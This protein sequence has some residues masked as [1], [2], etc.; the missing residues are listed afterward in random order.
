MGEADADRIP[1][2]E[3]RYLT[4]ELKALHPEQEGALYPVPPHLLPSELQDP[5]NLSA[6]RELAP[7]E[8]AD[9][10]I[11]SWLELAR[12]MGRKKKLWKLFKKYMYF[13]G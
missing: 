10:T 11:Q 12:R 7:Y 4:Y 3:L 2:W 1:V 6:G 8:M 5:A 13:G 9:L